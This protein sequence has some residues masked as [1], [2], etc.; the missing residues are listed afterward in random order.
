MARKADSD[1]HK[2]RRKAAPS[3]SYDDNDEDGEDADF[4]Q[5]RKRRRVWPYGVTLFLGW[6][7]IIGAVMFSRFL[8]D[9]PDV[10]TLLVR[11]ASHDITILD[12]NGKLIARRGLTQ[13]ELIDVSKLP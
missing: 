4:E 1:R 6:G 13:G 9:L 7:F 5:S 8:S 2:Q 3:A 11:G 12:R 10:G